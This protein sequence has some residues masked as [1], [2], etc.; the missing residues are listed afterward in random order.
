MH[1]RHAEGAL[2]EL[3]RGVEI[4]DGDSDV[5]DAAKH[6]ASVYEASM[7]LALVAN[8]RSGAGPDPEE[9]ASRLRSLGAADV[10][11]WPVDQAG[12]AEG[13][14]LVAAG[15]DGTVG[16]CAARAAQLGVPLAVVPAGTANDFARALGLPDDLDAALRLAV[17]GRDLRALELG[18]VADGPPFVNVVNAGL[19]PVAAREAAPLKARLGSLAYAVGAV[20]AAVR[21]A[22]LE[23]RVRLDDG[24]LFGGGAWQV[25][26]SCTG[27]FG[28]GSEVGAADPADGLLDVTVLPAGSRIGLLRRA[29]GLR[30]GDIA[31]QAGV[32]HGRG[33]VVDLRLP[34]GAE[35]N[36]D[37]ELVRRSRL[38]LTAQRAAF[39]L[40]VPPEGP[41]SA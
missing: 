7:R 11:V 22:P 13:D 31:A 34:P 23:C 6:G 5:V 33:H 30:R 26:V 37:G 39:E 17:D 28:G 36:V 35:V 20:R 9:L 14:R 27:A 1:E 8:P 4:Y 41:R 15:G 38:R 29:V 10:R 18:R 40:V 3:D 19:A 12:E 21:T 2:V 24:E 25:I 32:V 16:C